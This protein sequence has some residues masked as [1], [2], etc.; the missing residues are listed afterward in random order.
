MINVNDSP[1]KLS[2]DTYE[3]ILLLPTYVGVEVLKV[4]AFD[5]D[6]TSDPS[7]N[8]D[9]S[10]TP[11]LVYSLVDSNV[12]YFSVERFTGVVTVVNENLSKD[13]YRFNVKV[14]DYLSR[15]LLTQ[16]SSI[17]R[18]YGQKLIRKLL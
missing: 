6:M 5:P 13:R 8:P 1:P 9:T 16:G 12:E 17:F 11:Q 3:T 7:S 14:S 18:L 4:E 2:Q 10:I 15:V